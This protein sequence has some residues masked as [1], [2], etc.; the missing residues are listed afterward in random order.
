M[1]GREV[2]EGEQRVAIPDEALNRLVVFYAPGLDESVEGR[3]R[4]LPGLCHPDFLAAPAWLSVIGCFNRRRPSSVSLSAWQLSKLETSASPASRNRFVSER[5]NVLG[6][7]IRGLAYGN[8]L[9]AGR[10]TVDVA[11]GIDAVPGLFL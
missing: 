1:L 7:L 6:I 2:V 9:D 3:K 10:G 8:R 4:I 5:S 11:V